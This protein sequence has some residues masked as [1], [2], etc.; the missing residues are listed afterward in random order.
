[1]VVGYVVGDDGSMTDGKL[2]NGMPRD[3]VDPADE[4]RCIRVR[5]KDD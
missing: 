3:E 2:R 5:E 1:M 4:R